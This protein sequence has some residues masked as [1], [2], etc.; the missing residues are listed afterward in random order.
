MSLCDVKRE[1]YCSITGIDMQYSQF[2]FKRSAIELQR[3]KFELLGEIWTGNTAPQHQH[4]RPQFHC[5]ERCNT[6]SYLTP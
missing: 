6:L 3:F 5:A 1:V 4:H 2:N